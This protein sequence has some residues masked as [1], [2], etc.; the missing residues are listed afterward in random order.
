MFS[1]SVRA[2]WFAPTALMAAGTLS[3]SIPVLAVGVGAVG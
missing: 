3:T 2:I 1:E